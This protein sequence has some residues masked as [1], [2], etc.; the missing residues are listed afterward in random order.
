TVAGGFFGSFAEANFL[1]SGGAFSFV[2]QAL[3][4]FSTG[5]LGQSTSISF[6][7]KLLYAGI[8]LAIFLGLLGLMF[9]VSWLCQMAYQRLVLLHSADKTKPKD[10]TLDVDESGA[11]FAINIE[12][13]DELPLTAKISEKNWFA[14]WIR[15]LPFLLFLS[16]VFILISLGTN[17]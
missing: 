10:E 3:F 7:K 13:S 2:V 15:I 1:V 17:V 4:T 12:A 9:V 8:L 5:V 6:S 16:I 14:F 11:T